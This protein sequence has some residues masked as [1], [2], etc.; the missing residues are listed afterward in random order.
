M[1]FVVEDGTGVQA[2][3]AFISVAQFKDHHDTRGNDYS[4]LLPSDTV[5][6]EAIVRATDYLNMRFGLLFVGYVSEH[7]NQGLSWPRQDAYYVSGKQISGVPVE[8]VQ[9]TAE[10]ALR[11][12]SGSL[13]PDI[14]YDITNAPV[15]EREERA[16]P[17]VERYKFGGGGVASSFRRYPLAD[18]LLD[19]VL[20]GR[21]STYLARA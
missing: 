5:I 4:T 16:G 19:P 1:A 20:S 15:T 2:A 11:A 9:A 17:I 13:A 7:S 6:Q 10:Y 12:A 18:K 8:V 14:T 3:N 21:G